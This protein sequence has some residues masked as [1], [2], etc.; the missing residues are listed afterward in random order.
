VTAVG[1][2]PLPV[3]P[4]LIGVLA[5][6]VA[7]SSGGVLAWRFPGTTP[8][9]PD[10]VQDGGDEHDRRGDRPGQHVD[11]TVRATLGSPKVRTQQR[12]LQRPSL[13]I[14][15]EPHADQDGVQTVREGR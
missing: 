3:P 15:V 6:V 14:R 13:T 12:R 4:W 10:P 8:L 9:P 2:P 5:F 7:V 1:A 11:F